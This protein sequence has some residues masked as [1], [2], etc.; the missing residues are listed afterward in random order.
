MTTHPVVA[1]RAPAS[2]NLYCAPC[3]E[4]DT[5]TALTSDDLPDGSVC[6]DCGVDILIPPESDDPRLALLR[7]LNTPPYDTA[8]GLQ[9]SSLT[10][11]AQLIDAYRAAVVTEVVEALN[12]KGAELSEL[13]EEKMQPS[14]E[15][16]A[17]T[18]YEAAAAAR[19][20]KRA[21]GEVSDGRA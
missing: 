20:L 13:A 10:E 2:N 14:I 9:G 7:A 21:P 12:A 15:E 4:S 11:A 16:R 19:K 5:S 8:A 18:W 3:G 6:V 1:Y 17:Q